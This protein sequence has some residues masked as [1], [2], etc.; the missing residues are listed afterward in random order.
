MEK[1]TVSSVHNSHSV[2]VLFVISVFCIMLHLVHNL[3]FMST[4]V[5]MDLGM[6][7]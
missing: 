4:F 3:Y 6:G 2:A 1:E 5:Y 7:R